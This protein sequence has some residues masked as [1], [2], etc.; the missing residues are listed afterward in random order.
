MVFF[1]KTLL[2]NHGTT[3]MSLTCINKYIINNKQVS[4]LDGGS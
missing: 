3:H 2:M 1:K 4:V